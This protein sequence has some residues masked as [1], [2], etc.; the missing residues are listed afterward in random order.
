MALLLSENPD[1]TRAAI[2]AKKEEL[3]ERTGQAAFRR[4][5][6]VL[7]QVTS[8]RRALKAQIQQANR[9]KN[10]WTAFDH[11]RI[12]SARRNFQRLETSLATY[13]AEEFPLG[14]LA[15]YLGDLD[16]MYG[17]PFHQGLHFTLG[18]QS[19]T[20]TGFTPNAVQ[21][22]NA[23][24]M[25]T[26]FTPREVL[27]GGVISRLRPRRAGL[28]RPGRSQPVW[29][30]LLCILRRVCRSRFSMAGQR[31]QCPCPA[32][33]SRRAFTADWWKV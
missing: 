31:I 11:L 6:Q 29:C 14:R 21:C 8:A 22:K 16:W 33:S 18:E 7:A 24:G 12:A 26:T 30:R 4:K 19:Y 2:Q 13:S 28:K 9:R 5:C 27:R 3:A 1:A 10:G 32:T 17:L 20:V 15:T 25:Q 23:A